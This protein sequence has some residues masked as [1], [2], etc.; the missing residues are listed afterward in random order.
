MDNVFREAQTRV[1]GELFIGFPAG[2]EQCDGLPLGVFVS[3]FMFVQPVLYFHQITA[4]SFIFTFLC[5]LFTDCG[6]SGKRKKNG[7]R[8]FMLD[9]L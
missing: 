7:V 2:K 3:V 8:F 5:F 4:G 6:E 1:G 9:R